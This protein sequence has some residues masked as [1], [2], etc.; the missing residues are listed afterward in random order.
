[1]TNECKNLDLD[2]KRLSD[3][4]MTTRK[5]SSRFLILDKIY[6]LYIFNNKVLS[7]SSEEQG[8]HTELQ[9]FNIEQPLVSIATPSPNVL[10]LLIST[11]IDL[12]EISVAAQQSVLNTI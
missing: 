9:I 11:M 12:E 1:M 4:S 7:V 6:K 8:M 2:V 10:A 5:D 3:R